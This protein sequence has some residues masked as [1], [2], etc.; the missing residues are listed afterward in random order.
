MR[1]TR[2]GLPTV[3]S[4]VQECYATVDNPDTVEA[5]KILSMA[6]ARYQQLG[7]SPNAVLSEKAC[8][9]IKSKLRKYVGRPLTKGKLASYLG[10]NGVSVASPKPPAPTPIAAV[11]TLTDLRLAKEY[12]KAAGGIK[13]A[14][15]LL[16]YLEELS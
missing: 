13:Q 15:E 1:R 11:V 14:K 10:S 7:G 6:R 8:G 12:A 9:N 2:N 16:S 4:V 3:T 5:K